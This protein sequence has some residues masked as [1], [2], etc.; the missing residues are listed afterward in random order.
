VSLTAE[1]YVE[2]R[3]C[4]GARIVKGHGQWTVTCPAHDDHT[5]SLRV[6]EGREHP[7]VL[8]CLAGCSTAEV[9][10][11]DG[12]TLAD[13]CCVSGC[14]SRE[15][16]TRLLR[17]KEQAPELQQLG[18]MRIRSNE[19]E[20]YPH[21]QELTV[22]IDPT[23]NRRAVEEERF[24]VGEL[25][26]TLPSRSGKNMVLVL[27][28]MVELANERLAGGRNCQPIA[29]GTLQAERALGV[30]HSA[31]SEAL[32]SLERHGCIERVR[33]L[34]GLFGP[35]REGA[36]AWTFRLVV[37]PAIQ[38]IR[39]ETRFDFSEERNWNRAFAGVAAGH[40]VRARSHATPEEL[41]A[42]LGRAA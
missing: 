38:P 2:L 29:Y 36:G 3:Q 39:K 28:H 41:D 12:L 27:E 6:R 1:E 19:V 5:P 31:A 32:R 22:G 33:R 25:N 4:R 30:R 21:I 23:G 24:S 11:A 18:Y 42:M 34:P 20:H 13:L 37:T 10:A 35:S 17:G 9:L 16:D 14:R 15:T 7:V 26:V 8:H 40:H